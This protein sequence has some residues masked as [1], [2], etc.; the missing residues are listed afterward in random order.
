M[1][2]RPEDRALELGALEAEGNPETVR[3]PCHA[4]RDGIGLVEVHVSGTRHR[5]DVR[6]I[7]VGQRAPHPQRVPDRGQEQGLGKGRFDEVVGAGVEAGGD[8][9]E[10]RRA[11]GGRRIGEDD[12]GHGL[13]RGIGP[14]PATR[15]DPVGIR[16]ADTEEYRL[17]LSDGDCRE[18]GAPLGDRSNRVARGFE[19]G[20]Q[21]RVPPRF[22]LDDEDQS[23]A[24]IVPGHARTGCARTIG[25]TTRTKVPGPWDLVRTSWSTTAHRPWRTSGPHRRRRR[26]GTPSPAPRG[27]GRQR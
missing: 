7:H 11:G 3:E 14:D 5:G 26:D 21:R 13:V 27:P 8:V 22:L 12:D 19:R 16:R 1:D 24:V 17:W 4:R 6:G 18:G 10:G 25:A 9:I 23:P 15:L 2:E 20:R